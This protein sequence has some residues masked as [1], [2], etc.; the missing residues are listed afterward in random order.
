M[1]WISYIKLGKANSVCA[2]MW[3]C[4]C[5]ERKR[6]NWKEGNAG[7]K[8]FMVKSNSTSDLG[9]CTFKFILSVYLRFA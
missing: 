6:D 2:F 1:G 5:G 7:W 4:V 9:L 8:C 3:V